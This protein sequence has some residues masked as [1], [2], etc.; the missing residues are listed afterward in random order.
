MTRILCL[1][2]L[3]FLGSASGVE[4]SALKREHF[5]RDPGWEGNNNR[6]EIKSP[7]VVKQDFG[8]SAKSVAGKTKG[9]IGGS[10]TRTTKPAYYAA[11]IG[12]KTLN[13]KL[14][15]SGTFAIPACHPGA[16]LFFG[17]FNANQPGGSGRPIGSLGLHF[18]FEGAG[19]RLAV[20][21]ITGQNQSCGTFITPYIPG[22][23]RPTP[24]RNDG[25][26]YHWTL[27]YDPQA[28]GGKGRFTF[29]LRSDGHKPGELETPDLPAAHQ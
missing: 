18:D 24:I 17:F 2:A 8:Y 20:R 26:R 6:T 1:I 4:P 16:G 13:D 28:G 25:T 21:L 15:A 22:K 10:V 27:D 12:P 23:F 14:S 29:T 5:D 7:P 3:S 9:E 11:K 19:G